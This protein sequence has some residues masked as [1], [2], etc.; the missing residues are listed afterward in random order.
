MFDLNF[1]EQSSYSKEFILFLNFKELDDNGEILNCLKSGRTTP[2][3]SPKFRSFALTLHFYSPKAYNYLRTVF[4]H[5]L[6]APSTI[7]GW[8]RSVDGSPGISGDAL[9]ELKILASDANSKGDI[10]LAASMMDEITLH[11]SYQWSDNTNEIMGEV[12]LGQ[13]EERTKDKSLA[14]QALVY[15]INGINTKFKIPVA[16]FLIDKMKSKEKALITRQVILAVSKTG[17]RVISLTFDGLKGNISVCRFLGANFSLD[18]PFIVNPHSCDKVFLFWDAAHMEK[19]AR[20]RL[21]HFGILYNGHGQ[22]IEWRYF[23]SLVEFQEKLGCQLGNKLTRTHLQWFRKKMNVRM[24]CE[25][26]SLSV[27]NALE[28]LRDLGHDE[29]QE[30]DATVEYIKYMNN[31]FD[32]LNS[33]K[34]NARHFKRP[35]SRET[36][37]E[38]FEY[39]DKAIKYISDLKIELD[40]PSILGTD[41][42]TAFFGFIQNMK[43]VKN[44]YDEYIE[45][46]IIEV[47]YTFSLSQDH[48]ELLFARVCIANLNFSFLNSN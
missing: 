11:Q 39:I 47:L 15:L 7:R 1:Q 33:K 5:H 21:A 24:A 35:I 34:P 16:Y 31:I 36:R 2:S 27:A 45:T 20:G 6:P 42:K 12:D 25:T 41:S 40:G 48:L 4:G 22:K 8:Y 29:F 38:Y 26:F 3:Y 13:N 37:D 14:R 43:N 17:V 32:I 10:I 44:I 46:N 9:N 28:Y 18:M 19:L 23:V 30:C